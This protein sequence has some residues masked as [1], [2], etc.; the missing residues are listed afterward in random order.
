MGENI[1]GNVA[2]RDNSS[3]ALINI[4]QIILIIL[5]YL[6]RKCIILMEIWI[7]KLI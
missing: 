3:S 4:I 1:F 2:R 5:D 7:K 6:I